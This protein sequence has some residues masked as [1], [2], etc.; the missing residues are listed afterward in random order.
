MFPKNVSREM[1]NRLV[2]ISEFREAVLL[3]K[4]L[5]VPL[6]EKAPRRSD[7]QFVLDQVNR[8][9]TAWKAKNLS[10]AGRVTLAKSV[11]E[12]IPMSYDDCHDAE[13]LFGRD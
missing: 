13:E 5:G 2:Q 7:F 6:T 12:G 8:K 11:I 3:W 4:Y 9:L 1:R 10:F